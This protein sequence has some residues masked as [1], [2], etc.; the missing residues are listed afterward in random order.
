MKRRTLMTLLAAAPLTACMREQQTTLRGKTMGTSYVVKL[1]SAQAQDERS[2]A[3]LQREIDQLLAL[4]NRSMSTYDPRSELSRFNQS[5]STGWTP[6]SP[7]LTAV[8]HE[9]LQVSALSEGAFDPTVGPLVNLWGFGPDRR[10]PAVPSRVSLDATRKR[11]GYHYLQVRPDERLIRKTRAAAYVDLSGIAKGYGVDRVAA[12]IEAR[13]SK[14]YLVEIGGEIRC[15]GRNAGGQAW[16]IAIEQPRAGGRY[17]QRVIDLSGQALATSGD[18]RQFFEHQGRRYS[19]MIDPLSGLPA[20]HGLASVSVLSP[21][22][23]QADALAT[24][25]QVLGPE[26]G[27]QLA[28]RHDLEALFILPG[29]NGTDDFVERGTSAFRRRQQA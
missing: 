11:V 8:L 24:A 23:M 2:M 27:Y 14:D 13:G 17:V 28:E 9:A 1:A 12:L 3:L 16:Q 26:R 20:G 22:T 25:L 5:A 4:L 18:Y 15:R 29:T 10:A 6:A 21:S 19:H 7:D